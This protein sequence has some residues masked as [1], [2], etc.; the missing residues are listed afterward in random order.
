M[1]SSAAYVTERS[2]IECCVR[3]QV[4]W[5]DILMTNQ[6]GV[7]VFLIAMSEW[8]IGVMDF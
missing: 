8:A 4:E 1:T 6:L 3:W 5:I 7:K 2:E